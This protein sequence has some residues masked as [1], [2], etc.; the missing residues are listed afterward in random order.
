[1]F[2]PTCRKCGDKHYNFM[3]CTEAVEVEKVA[4]EKREAAV[5]PVEWRSREGER[6]WGDRLESFDRVGDVFWRRRED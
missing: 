6:E 3:G 2:K 1:M 5:V 4:E